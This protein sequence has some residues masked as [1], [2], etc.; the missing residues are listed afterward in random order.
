M[1]K[2]GDS[3]LVVFRE[4]LI[5]SSPSVSADNIIVMVLLVTSFSFV[6]FRRVFP[7][8]FVRI[9]CHVTSVRSNALLHYPNVPYLWYLNGYPIFVSQ[10]VDPYFLF[11][12]GPASTLRVVV[13][14]PGRAYRFFTYTY[15][16][17]R[18]IRAIVR[19]RCLVP[20]FFKV[21][22]VKWGCSFFR[23]LRLF[24]H[25][26]LHYP[27]NTWSLWGHPCLVSVFSVLGNG[28]FCGHSLI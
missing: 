24:L 18:F 11:R 15:F 1:G 14:I 17:C 3:S 9:K 20:I 10:H 21:I 19:F 7:A 13:V 28:P 2:D 12:Y 16:V 22:G 27:P 23:F 26:P 5:V 4:V 8:S 6:L 25:S